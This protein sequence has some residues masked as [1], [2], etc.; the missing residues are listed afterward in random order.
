MNTKKL[1]NAEK[2][3]L[4]LNTILVVYFLMLMIIYMNRFLDRISFDDLYPDHN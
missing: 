2:M 3:S 4:A 1:L